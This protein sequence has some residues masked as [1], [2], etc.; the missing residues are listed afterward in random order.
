MRK[1]AVPVL[2]LAVSAGCQSGGG[3]HTNEGMKPAETQTGEA[4]R[5]G[6]TQPAATR[7]MK[8]DVPSG[9]APK[10]LYWSA[11]PAVVLQ[12][13]CDST[14][15][16][17]TAGTMYS[18]AT[19]AE[20]DSILDRVRA[21]HFH[22]RRSDGKL[23]WPPRQ[24]PPDALIHFIVPVPIH[25]DS[26]EAPPL[27]VSRRELEGAGLGPWLAMWED[28]VPGWP[29]DTWRYQKSHEL[30][31][32]RDSTIID[33]KDLVSRGMVSISPDSAWKV[34]P[35]VYSDIMPDG[36]LGRDPD[37]GFIVYRNIPGP[38]RHW[39]QVTGTPIVYLSA[40]WIDAEHFVVTGVH[41]VSVSLP[42][43]GFSYNAP[44]LILGKVNSPT[45][46]TILG[47]PLP[48][49]ETPEMTKRL[50]RFVR[51][52]YRSAWNAPGTGR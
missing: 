47:P 28:L 4:T 48:A 43:E 41:E 35:F 30:S 50:D 23:W 32:S 10:G 19:P 44:M 6:G 25:P 40:N 13:A 38:Q 21:V 12:V 33:D 5:T 3:T 52:R 17:V 36:H 24:K 15:R 51:E 42:G 27:P 26:A 39:G 9:W 49:W 7:Q 31:E 16:V 29:F 34:H 18:A 11:Y 37:G 2:L 8:L 46:T 1:L 45:V 22:I 20:T 14:G